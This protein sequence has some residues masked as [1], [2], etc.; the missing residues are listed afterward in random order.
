MQERHQS[1]EHSMKEM[2]MK[3]LSAPGH[4]GSEYYITHNWTGERKKKQVRLSTIQQLELHEEPTGPD[5][6]F[7]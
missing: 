6:L 2:L 3:V 1:V 7:I 5:G 4:D